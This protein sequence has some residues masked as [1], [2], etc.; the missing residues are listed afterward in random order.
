MKSIEIFTTEAN[1]DY[2]LLDSGQGEK[3]EKYGEVVLSRPD[4]QALWLKQKTT[5]LWRDAQAS[6]ERNSLFAKWHFKMGTPKEWI[7]NFLDLRFLVRPTAFKHTGLFPEQGANWLWTEEK[8]KKADR[9]ISVLNLFGYTGGAT[10]ACL[11]AGASVCH[12]DGSKTAIEWAQKNAELS[13][14][15]D[16]PVRFLVDD[17]RKFVEREIRRGNKYDAIIM[18]PPTFGHGA[19]K[20]V[21]KI[22]T[23]LLP[24]LN[25]VQKILSDKPLFI[26]INGYA[27]GYSALAYQNILNP[28]VKKYGGKIESGELAIREM[29]ETG[30]LLPAGISARWS[31]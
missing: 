29:G 26:I 25:N 27:A 24:L 12:V 10:L 8:I 17:V 6:F 5:E 9:P 7:I 1:G 15:K 18:D 30:R 28:I 22:E 2:A 16:K 14:L 4:P 21:W 23:D 13:G 11:R 20:E 19:K 31:S 3:L